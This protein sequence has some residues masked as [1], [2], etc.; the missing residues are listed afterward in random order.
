[1]HLPPPELTSPPLAD[2]AKMP[3]V[4][5][6]SG[7]GVLTGTGTRGGEGD[8]DGGG[9]DGDGDG[10]GGKGGGE[11]DGGGERLTHWTSATQGLTLVYLSA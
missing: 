1:M 9:G 4:P 3:Q 2:G 5:S 10:G 8:G 7:A 6:P 11:G